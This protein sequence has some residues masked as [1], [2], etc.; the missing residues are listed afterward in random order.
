MNEINSLY[1]ENEKLKR[2]EEKEIGKSEFIIKS[3][4]SIRLA[5]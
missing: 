5:N 3:L 1:K 4:V 2:K